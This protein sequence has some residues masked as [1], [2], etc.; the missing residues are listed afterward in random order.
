LSP[1]RPPRLT[2]ERQAAIDHA[3]EV[4]AL[5]LPWGHELSRA[6]K[7]MSD[8]GQLDTNILV[9]ATIFGPPLEG[10]PGARS[11]RTRNADG[12]EHPAASNPRGV[13]QFALSEVLQ[14]CD[15]T[16][17]GPCLIGSHGTYPDQIKNGWAALSSFLS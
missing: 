3:I 10:T 17:C 12:D 6:M 1:Y 8:D 7:C 13:Q 5:G 2:P 15:A 9:Y 4:M 11:T 16:T 14:G